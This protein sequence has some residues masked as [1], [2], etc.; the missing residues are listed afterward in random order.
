MH[1]CC[2]VFGNADSIACL[3]P[4]RPSLQIINISLTPLFFKSVSTASRNL[5]VSFSPI[6]IPNISLYPFSLTP[7]TTYAAFLVTILSVLTLK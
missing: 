5:A 3:I 7:K 1:L 4:E 2:T 6:Q